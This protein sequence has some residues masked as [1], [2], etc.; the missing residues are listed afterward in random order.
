M[1][2]KPNTRAATRGAR[3]GINT[4]QQAQSG[5][6]Q[7][8]SWAETPIEMQDPREAP[9]HQRTRPRD[10]PVAVSGA[11]T[12]RQEQ[13]QSQTMWPPR[14]QLQQQESDRAISVQQQPQTQH[15]MAAGQIAAQP[16]SAASDPRSRSPY[17]IPEPTNPHPALFAPIASNGSHDAPHRPGSIPLENSQIQ[18]QPAAAPA[19]KP[20]QAPS[21]DQSNRNSTQKL[22]L[23]D[24]SEPAHAFDPPKKQP[25]Q[26][27]SP[28]SLQNLRSG[29]NNPPPSSHR[30][31]QI[32]H[33]NMALSAGTA[34]PAWNHSLCECSA[35]VGTCLEGVFCPC[36][37]DGRTSY[38]LD[39]K[40][41][42][43]DPTDMLGFERC[44]TRCVIFSGTLCCGLHCTLIACLE[45]CW[46]IRLEFLLTL[47]QAC[48]PS[49]VG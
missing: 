43:R 10:A 18:T 4:A 11:E 1:A 8:F 41:R 17:N 40:E 34:A 48:C 27:F 31:G 22:P 5:G 14:A 28:T 24:P 47:L 32:S 12:S 19:L 3:I 6:N 35:D 30:P 44:N 45:S 20:T 2:S 29:H 15:Q 23:S 37:L 38:R 49:L 33:P 25:T 7:R 42:H 16:V 21:E 36:M 39:A 46:R 9:F 13:D 26:I